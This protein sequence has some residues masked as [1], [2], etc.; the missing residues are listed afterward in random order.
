MDWFK[1][2]RACWPAIVVM[3][4]SVLAMAVLAPLRGSP[5]TSS[6]FDVL[7]WAP[8]AGMGFAL[9]YGSWVAYRLVQAARGGGPLCPRCGGP[10]GVEKYTPYSPHRTCLSCG[11]HANERHYR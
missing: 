2:I 10:L 11:K 6:L 5:L 1:V 9:F 4:A 7:R 8:Q 3:V